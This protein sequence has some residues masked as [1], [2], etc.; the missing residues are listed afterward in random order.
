M[1][2]WQAAT[3]P[4]IQGSWNLHNLTVQLSNHKAENRKEGGQGLDFFILMSSVSG[5][6]G[7][8]AQ[9]NYCAGNTFEDALAHYRR[10]NGFPATSLNIGLVSD[11]SHFGRGTMSSYG[12]VDEYLAMFG[13]LAP[14]TVTTEEMFASVKMVLTMSRSRSNSGQS[15]SCDIPTQLIVGI[16]DR[17]PRHEDLLNRWPMDRKFDHRTASDVADSPGQGAGKQSIGKF[18][19]QEMMA[20][21]KD[22]GDARR[23]VEELLRKKVAQATGI[24][25]DSVDAER[26]LVTFGIDSLKA[27]E[28]RNWVTK[29]LKSELSVFDILSPAPISAL[30]LTISTRSKMFDKFR[31]SK[32]D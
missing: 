32:D 14:V 21:A 22:I 3:K 4:K 30:S 2:Q 31:D 15:T 26:S 25:V 17:I 9:A 19:I 10:A 29:T 13:H 5:V 28:I 7:N 1:D 24:E 23:Y 16:S 27:T 12:N 6:I 11:S 18:G 20:S 8:S